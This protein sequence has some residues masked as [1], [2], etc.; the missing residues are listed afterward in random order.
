MAQDFSLN[1]VSS[2]NWYK[3]GSP[4]PDAA[5]ANVWELMREFNALG[6]TDPA[7]AEALLRAMLADGSSLPGVFAPIYF[8]F[9]IHTTF[10]E[11]CFLNYNCVILDVA[12]VTVGKRTLFG[13]ACQ[14]ITVEHPVDNAQQRAD[15]WERGRPVRIGDDCWFGA[16]AMVLPGVTVGD[17][18]VIAAGTVVTRDIPDDSLVTGVPGKVVR[19]LNGAGEESAG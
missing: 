7:R 16:G 5:H 13:P 6:N 12:E 8:E 4:E 2:G 19:K 11:D 18:C 1:D 15:G 14:I 3:P 9:G 10:G 17:R